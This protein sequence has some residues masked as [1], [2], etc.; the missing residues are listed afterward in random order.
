MRQCWQNSLSE[1]AAQH[2][3][4]LGLREDRVIVVLDERTYV[5]LT[6]R[7]EQIV[8]FGC[9]V[10]AI[11]YVVDVDVAN[12]VLNLRVIRGRDPHPNRVVEGPK[13]PT[14]L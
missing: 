5:P 13:E 7:H 14:T 9:D 4:A 1:D 11:H 2:C 12:S 6:R 8:V 3:L 10:L